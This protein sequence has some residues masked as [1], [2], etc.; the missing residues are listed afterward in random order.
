MKGAANPLPKYTI[1]FTS[2]TC[3]FFML[4]GKFC[5]TESYVRRGGRRLPHGPRYATERESVTHVSGDAVVGIMATPANRARREP[6]HRLASDRARRT[7][8]L[9]R[10]TRPDLFP[11]VLVQNG[12]PSS[13]P[14]SAPGWRTCGAVSPTTRAMRGING[15]ATL[16]QLRVEH[17]PAK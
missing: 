14:P 6:P 10:D 5:K 9:Y 1:I 11:S 13:A 7:H 17:V 8:H 16:I 2:S 4:N 3:R 15:R 12:E